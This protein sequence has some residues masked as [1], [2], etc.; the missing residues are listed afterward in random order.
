MRASAT[1]LFRLNLLRFIDAHP[2][3]P[4]ATISQRAGK[5]KDYIRM[6][7]NKPDQSPTL[8]TAEKIARQIG[9]TLSAMISSPSDDVMKA[10]LIEGFSRLDDRGRS[11][12]LALIRADLRQIDGTEEPQ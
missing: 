4:P 10:E 1:E 9:T 11:Q 5:S 12:V 8:D 3:L 7:L 6:L 2:D